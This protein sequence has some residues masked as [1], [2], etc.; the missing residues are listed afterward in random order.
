[1]SKDRNKDLSSKVVAIDIGRSGVKLS[2]YFNGEVSNKFIPSAVIPATTLSFDPTPEI[3]RQNTVNLYGVDYFV[4]ET[5][6]KQGAVNTVGHNSDWINSLEHRVLVVKA[7]QLLLTYGIKPELI[8]VGLPVNTFA[9]LSG[10]LAKQIKEYFGNETRV[11]PIP[12]PWGVYQNYLLNDEGSVITTN[13][14]NAKIAIIDVGHFT[15]DYMLID[16]GTW[17]QNASY[18][19]KGIYATVDHL[20][21]ALA[22]E[23]ITA[24]HLECFEV[25]KTKTIKSYGKLIDKTKTVTS[26]LDATL[27]DIH[28]NTNRLFSSHARSIDQFIIAGGGS[29]YLIEAMQEKWPQLSPASDPRHAVAAGMRKFGL[30]T[31]KKTALTG[32]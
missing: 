20:Q 2:F 1:M 17:V 28:Q 5:A 13:N 19:G 22:R 16:S 24:S 31:Y 25:L 12:Q 3:T 15:T 32:A 30:A 23:G 18:S 27:I 21:H 10:D 4:G 7:Q 6:I 8:V 11:M 26:A 29:I 14:S 9:S